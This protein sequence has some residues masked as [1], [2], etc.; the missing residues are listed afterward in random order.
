MSGVPVSSSVSVVEGPV[1][2]GAQRNPRP[3]P[4]PVSPDGV[5][6]L[7]SSPTT[8]LPTTVGT[9][10]TLRVVRRRFRGE[11]GVGGVPGVRGPVGWTQLGP[12]KDNPTGPTTHSG[13]RRPWRGGSPFRWCSSRFGSGRY[14]TQDSCGRDTDL[15]RRGPQ[16]GYG[17]AWSMYVLFK[18][19]P[20]RHC[21]LS[22]PMVRP[23]H[24]S[25]WSGAPVVLVRT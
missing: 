1:G 22:T 23:S 7:P 15:G 13:P 16:V 2:P 4:C 10:P 8:S 18:T 25:V 11:V 14:L 17:P 24:E 20:C 6:P 9:C 19:N 12:E 3:G 21:S 5:G